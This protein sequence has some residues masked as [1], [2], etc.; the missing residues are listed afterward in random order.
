MNKS[1]LAHACAQHMY[2]ND[3]LSN[4]FGMQIKQMD[5]GTAVVT[6]QVTKSMVNGLNTCHGGVIFSLADTSF[7]FACNSQN[8]VAVAAGCNIDYLRPAMIDDV[9]SATS[10]MQY[11]GR[12]SG[13]YQTL[14]TNQDNKLI[15]VFKGNSARLGGAVL[16]T[17][18]KES[19]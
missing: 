13:I 5:E 17:A 9:L 18:A 1:E 15:A 2:A 19:I 8:E 16:N 14:I 6:M 11:Q 4:L 7:A 10:K 12:R 3:A